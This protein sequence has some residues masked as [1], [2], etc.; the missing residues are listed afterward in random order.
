MQIVRRIGMICG[1]DPIQISPLG[2]VIKRADFKGLFSSTI[3]LQIATLMDTAFRLYA[4]N[5]IRAFS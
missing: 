2:K 4:S 5:T 1:L 3:I